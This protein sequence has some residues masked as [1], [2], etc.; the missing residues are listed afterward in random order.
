MK[1]LYEID[2][3]H[4]HG[5]LAKMRG[6]VVLNGKR[7]ETHRMVPR[8]VDGYGFENKREEI[9]RELLGKVA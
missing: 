7:K 9:K 4:E 1:V 8:F 6:W 5:K 2:Y 3:S